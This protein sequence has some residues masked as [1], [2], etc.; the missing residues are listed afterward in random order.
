[1]INSDTKVFVSDVDGVVIDSTEE[2]LV[3]AWNGYQRFSGGNEYI[4]RPEE[5]DP[6]YS[7]HFRSIRN[8]VRSM[9][10]YLV[11]FRSKRGEITCQSAYEEKLEVL[12]PEDRDRFGRHFFAAREELKASDKKAWMDLHSVYP[13]IVSV[14][15]KMKEKY[16]TYVVTGKDRKSVLDFFQFFDLAINPEMIFDKDAAK[17]KLAA[18][19]KIAAMAHVQG[20]EICFLDDNVTHLAGPH[21]SGFDVVLAAW[22]YGMPEHFEMAEKLNIS[23]VTIADLAAVQKSNWFKVR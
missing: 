20:Y 11:V 4:S 14:I 2:C 3:V 9:D 15:R 8:Y 21:K 6:D 13:G 5:S 23:V 7:R 17:N 18:L 22:G 16:V 19:E 10:E 1:M 12:S